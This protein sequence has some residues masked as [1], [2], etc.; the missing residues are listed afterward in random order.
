LSL[1]TFCRREQRPRIG[2]GVNRVN[3]RKSITGLV[4][5]TLAL[6]AL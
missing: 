3:L 4:V 6:L 2:G 5:I 1:A